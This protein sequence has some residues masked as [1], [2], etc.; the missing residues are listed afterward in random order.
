MQT[1]AALARGPYLHDE[2]IF[3]VKKVNGM[4]TFQECANQHND[5][6]TK[7]T[8]RVYMMSL[9]GYWMRKTRLLPA[10]DSMAK[11]RRVV[12]AQTFWVC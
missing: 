9:E 7:Q 5:I 1:N 10:L 11:L 3:L 2:L 4:I 8:V 12:W 6:L